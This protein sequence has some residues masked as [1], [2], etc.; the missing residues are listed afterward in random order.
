MHRDILALSSV[1]WCPP[2]YFLVLLFLFFS[3]SVC[4][5]V[6]LATCLP[7]CLPV[8]LCTCLPVFLSTCL[9]VCLSTCLPVSLPVYLCTCLPTCLPVYLSVSAGRRGQAAGAK[10][11]LDSR[12][13]R[14]L[15]RGTPPV[16]RG[17]RRWW[18]AA[19][20]RGRRAMGQGRCRRGKDVAPGD[21]TAGG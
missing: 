21:S 17:G 6:Y 10:R 11:S 9:P 16:E 19:A 2:P 5:P 12:A 18:W 14:G 4:L 1:S 20:A 15:G 13:G 7:A 8:Y 3:L